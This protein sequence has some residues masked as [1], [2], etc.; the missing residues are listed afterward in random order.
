MTM[1]TAIELIKGSYRIF[2]ALLVMG[3]WFCIVARWIREL[4]TEIREGET[5]DEG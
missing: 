4:I 2:W 1:N 3:Y 5:Q